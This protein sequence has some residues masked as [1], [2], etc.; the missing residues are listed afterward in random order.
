MGST[1]EP[2]VEEQQEHDDRLRKEKVRKR[3]N[4]TARQK[5]NRMLWPA[6]PQTRRP[7]PRCSTKKAT[8][9]PKQNQE[10]ESERK[11]NKQPPIWEV[12]AEEQNPRVQRHVLPHIGRAGALG[13]HAEIQARRA[14]KQRTC[15]TTGHTLPKRTKQYRRKH[16]ENQREEVKRTTAIQPGGWRRPKKCAHPPDR[17]QPSKTKRFHHNAICYVKK[18]ASTYSDENIPA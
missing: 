12:T 5:N 13:F 6:Q 18:Q 9:N 14:A 15:S 8:A 17:P 7:P 10:K 4:K 11:C 16:T 3:E 2:P 1:D